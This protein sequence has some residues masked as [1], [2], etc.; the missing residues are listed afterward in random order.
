MVFKVPV[1]WVAWV[2]DQLLL[3]CWHSYTNYCFRYFEHLNMV[4]CTIFH[5]IDHKTLRQD[6]RVA[7][8]G[9]VKAPVI[10]VV[11]V[12][13]PFLSFSWHSYKS[14]VSCILNTCTWYLLPSSMLLNTQ[15]TG[16][17]AE[18]SK[19]LVLGTSHFGGVGSSPTPVILL[20][21]LFKVLYPV[22]WTP[23]HGIFYDHVRY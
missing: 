17:M 7:E 3:F 1:T 8:R 6:G 22:F 14:I 21:R 19:A 23:A 10:L 2:R 11:W 12:W 16:R 20:T 18:W 13:V 9:L 5:A 4:S 15:H